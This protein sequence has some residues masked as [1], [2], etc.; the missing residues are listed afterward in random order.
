MNRKNNNLWRR[1]SAYIHRTFA[2]KIVAIGM[3]LFGLPTLILERDVTIMVMALAAGI[4]LFFARKNYI[5]CER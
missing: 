1:F 2:N 4:P 3:I 5:Y